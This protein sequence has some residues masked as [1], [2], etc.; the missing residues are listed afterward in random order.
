MIVET[1][2]VIR[3]GGTVLR[4][5]RCTARVVEVVDERVSAASQ[6]LGNRAERDGCERLVEQVLENVGE[7]LR[8]SQRIRMPWHILTIPDHERFL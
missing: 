1:D 3:G 5:L 6:G 2:F 4:W 7:Q 8:L